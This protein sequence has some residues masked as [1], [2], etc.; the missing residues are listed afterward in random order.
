MGF[1]DDED[2]PDDEDGTD[3]EQEDPIAF[4]GGVGFGDAMDVDQSFTKITSWKSGKGIGSAGFP[5]DG[6]WITS[7]NVHLLEKVKVEGGLGPGAGSVRPR[8]DDDDDD[9]EDTSRANGNGTTN[10]D[11]M[12]VDA[13]WRRTG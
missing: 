4:E 12:G 6:G 7:E 1:F 11:G 2:S 9:D 5:G 10:G 13:K 8:E 3:D